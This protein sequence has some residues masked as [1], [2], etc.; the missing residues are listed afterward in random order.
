MDIEQAKKIL[1]LYRPS[2]KGDAAE[3]LFA[4]APSFTDAEGSTLD[5]SPESVQAALELTHQNPELAAWYEESQAI[6]A[7]MM[8]GFQAIEPPADLR[9]KILAAARPHLTVASTTS[10]P[11]SQEIPELPQAAVPSPESQSRAEVS[12]SSDLNS[13]DVA[14]RGGSSAALP[15]WMALAASVIIALGV[16][17]YFLA[18]SGAG[19]QPLPFA[20]VSAEVPRMTQTHHHAFGSKR[21][22]IAEIRVWLKANGGTPDFDLPK[23]LEGFKG[24]NCE[25]ANIRGLRVSVI[26]LAMNGGRVVHLYVMDRARLTAPPPLLKPEFSQKGLYAMASWSDQ[27][28]SYILSEPGSEEK[29]RTLL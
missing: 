20:A 13:G 8:E 23:S 11:Q 6:D 18:G 14:S 7:G 15:L 25:V 26:C 22:D 3:P 21:N 9:D 2:V 16:S 1:R 10:S 12:R 28:F 24:V 4:E 5:L 27:R 19:S 17:Y 29:I